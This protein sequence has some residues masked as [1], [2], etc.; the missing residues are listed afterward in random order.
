MPSD[1]RYSA[2][3]SEVY[4]PP[5]SVRNRFTCV[6][7]SFSAR[8]FHSFNFSSASDLNF[9]RNLSIC[10]VAS[11]MKSGIYRPPQMAISRGPHMPE[12]TS[13]SGSVARKVV[14]VKGYRANCHLMKHSQSRLPVIFGALA[15]TFGKI[16]KAFS[17]TCARLRCHNIRPSASC[18]DACPVVLSSRRQL[19]VR[20]RV[21]E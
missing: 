14:G 6:L 17:P 13:C 1:F 3:F 2:K 7:N 19:V 15:T 5:P 12:C 11:S 16:S 20:W 21:L 18:R 10:L 8:A 4:L 9:N